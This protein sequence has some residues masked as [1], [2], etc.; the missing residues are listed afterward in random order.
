MVALQML[1]GVAALACVCQDKSLC[2]PLTTPAAKKEVIAFAPDQDA[3]KTYNLS[4]LTTIMKFHNMNDEVVC[5]GHAAGVR[6][7]INSDFDKTQLTNASYVNAFITNTQRYVKEGGY[8]G[9]NFDIEALSEN[10]DLLTSLVERTA[11]ALRSDNPLAQITFD[12]SISATTAGYDYAA[13]NRT[14][15]FFIPMAYDMCWGSKTAEPNSPMDGILKGLQAYNDMGLMH[16]VVLGLP[17]YGYRFPC[18]KP[19]P[20]GGCPSA[21]PFSGSWSF[22]FDQADALQAQATTPPAYTSAQDARFF[23]YV[24]S[25]TTYQMYYDD[26]HTLSTKYAL[27]ESKNLKGTAV[28]YAGCASPTSTGGA[29]MWAAL[30]GLKEL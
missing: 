21:M 3:W 28:W 30:E 8:D 13:L 14:L 1:F 6:V 20:E 5:A 4:S 16:K 18:S 2:K 17:W 19:S 25:G 29:A 11:A 26:A 27:I 24:S 9:Y 23:S 7:V 22:T 10:R 15:D 12:T